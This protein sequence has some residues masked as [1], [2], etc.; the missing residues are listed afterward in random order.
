M[1]LATVPPAGVRTPERRGHA[2]DGGCPPA[3]NR[4]TATPSPGSWLPE[5]NRQPGD[6]VACAI[7]G[8][9]IR[10]VRYRPGMGVWREGAHDLDD[11]FVIDGGLNAIMSK[12]V[13]PEAM[14]REMGVLHPWEKV[15]E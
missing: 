7:F 11:F 2:R 1:A 5:G 9:P 8:K 14:G 4:L 3:M 13:D 15:V 12:D 10:V 6:T